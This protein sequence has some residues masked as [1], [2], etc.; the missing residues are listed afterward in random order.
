[1]ALC[2]FSAIAGCQEDG[3]MSRLMPHTSHI[4]PRT[5][6]PITTVLT[7]TMNNAIYTSM[8]FRNTSVTSNGWLTE[9]RAFTEILRHC[10]LRVGCNQQQKYKMA[11]FCRVHRCCNNCQGRRDSKLFGQPIIWAGCSGNQS[12]E[13]AVQTT[14]HLSKLFRQPIIWTGCSGNQSFEQGSDELDETV[15]HWNPPLACS[16]WSARWWVT[17][18]LCLGFQIYWEKNPQ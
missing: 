15:E 11:A 16:Q 12:F 6:I 8:D 2:S 9:L 1:M 10:R 5:P 13:Q 18:L 7:H 14:N 17:C 3:D 4:E